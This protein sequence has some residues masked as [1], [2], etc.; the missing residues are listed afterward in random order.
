MPFNSIPTD[1]FT[2]NEQYLQ[3][4]HQE[5][6]HS[7]VQS[8]NFMTNSLDRAPTEFTQ[9]PLDDQLLISMMELKQQLSESKPDLKIEHIHTDLVEDSLNDYFPLNEEVQS[10]VDKNLNDSRVYDRKTQAANL[11]IKILLALH[12]LS[13]EVCSY[14]AYIK[15]E[16]FT[17]LRIESKQTNQPEKQYIFN[18]LKDSIIKKDTTLLYEQNRYG[19]DLDEELFKV[20]DS[21]YPSIPNDLF[22]RSF[23][24]EDTTIN[25][26]DT[27]IRNLISYDREV[28]VSDN[29]DQTEQ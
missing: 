8:E 12:F 17:R 20:A 7:H 28:N 26:E 27:G 10:I 11:D 1:N 5:V 25:T 24:T 13:P 29:L 3:E 23:L 18:Y 2:D 14:L 21:L 16:V 19:C 4:I 22:E 9:E 6:N 15:P